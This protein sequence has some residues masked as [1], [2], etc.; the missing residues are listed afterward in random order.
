MTKHFRMQFVDHCGS[1][2]SVIVSFEAPSGRITC[3]CD[4][5]VECDH[6]HA[7]SVF[8]MSYSVLGMP[9]RRLIS[10]KEAT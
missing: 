7:A 8:D 9:A 1:C 2:G 5:P 4:C 6:P 3:G 10:S